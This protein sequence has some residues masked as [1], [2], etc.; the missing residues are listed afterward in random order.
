MSEKHVARPLRVTADRRTTVADRTYVVKIRTRLHPTRDI[1]VPLHDVRFL[2]QIV[3]FIFWILPGALARYV[4]RVGGFT[5]T[6]FALSGR[7]DY[8][9]YEETRYRRERKL[10]QEIVSSLPEAI[11]RADTIVEEIEAGRFASAHG[12]GDN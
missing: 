3:R 6:V 2:I 10:H 7:E 1:R 9:M 11:H 8:R 4:F 12:A 5:I